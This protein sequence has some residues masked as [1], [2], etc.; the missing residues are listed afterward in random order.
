MAEAVTKTYAYH[1]YRDDVFL[2]Q[3]QNVTSPFQLAQDINSAFAQLTVEIAFAAGATPAAP[4]PLLDE[5]G[6]ILLDEN[7]NPL[8]PEVIGDVFGSTGDGALIR[9]NNDIK[10]FEYSTNDPNG[11]LVFDGYM[12]TWNASFGSENSVV[13]EC[14]SNG[15]DLTDYIVE[16]DSPELIVEQAASTGD[17]AVQ[18]IDPS[19]NEL[20]AQAFTPSDSYSIKQIS[21]NLKWFDLGT[22]ATTH[23]IKLSLYEG[24]PGTV[25]TG[26]SPLATATLDDGDQ[27][28]HWADFAFQ[29]PVEVTGGTAYYFTLQ[30]AGNNA[31][32]DIR[33]STGDLYVG[34][35][36]YGPD[37]VG[38]AYTVFPTFEMTFRI[39]AAQFTDKDP[40]IM[41]RQSIDNYVAQGGRTN[42][43]GSSTDLTGLSATYTPKLATMAEIMAACLS[44]APADFFWYIDPGSGVI[45]FKETA[46]TP[47]HTFTLGRHIE[48]LELFATS[49]Y[50]R[51]V[52]YFTGGQ[53]A[54]GTNLFSLYT[55]PQSITEWR[56]RLDRIGDNRAKTQH[57]ANLIVDS[58]LNERPAPQYQSPLT[59]LDGTYDIGSINLGDTVGFAGFGN[60]I[61]FLVLRVSRI[62]RHP[63]KVELVVGRLPIRQTDHI[64]QAKEDVAKIQTVD[65]PD[66]PS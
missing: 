39:Y 62:T 43:S 19:V 66:T 1:V 31:E 33:F 11:V 35:H 47:T 6:N 46:D 44:L 34:G 4:E 53:M 58:F 57:A 32:F 40:T 59:I 29:S 50:I 14:L 36:Y 27:S 48:K 5:N 38:T 18:R 21:V 17:D 54:N 60:F 55:N 42:Y 24:T 37:Q 63:D 56:Q 15:S 23:R 3:I 61:D 12:E 20:V 49:E 22:E 65:N 26:G 51:N 10:V 64:K 28:F 2:G 13:I 25:E 41:L 7:G 16:L 8:Y 45:Y 52:V 30:S 9:M